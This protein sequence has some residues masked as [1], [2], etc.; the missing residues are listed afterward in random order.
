MSYENWMNYIK[1]AE[2]SSFISGKIR[3]IYYKFN[4]SKEMCEEYNMETGIL[5]RRAW[6]K[7]QNILSTDDGWE[8]ELGDTISNTK[9][10]NQIIKETNKAPILTKRITRHNIEWRIRNL[11]YPLE[12][13][14]IT[15][16][17]IKRAIIIRTKNKKYFKEIQIP[18]LS[19]CNIQIQQKA[20]SISH[21]HNTLIITYR[22]P[23][24]VQ[25][26][27][28]DTLKM[29]QEVETEAEN[30]DLVNLTKLLDF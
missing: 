21:Q 23:E 10:L 29:L 25:Q 19:R 15:A 30:V 27:E 11:P 18:E 5:F 26:M 1:N 9:D 12:N 22:K 6:K 17:N 2:K 13:Y 3:K 14:L 7:K 8:I 16:D 20:M 24:L 4:D 28:Q